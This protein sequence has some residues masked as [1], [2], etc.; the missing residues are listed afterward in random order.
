M[1]KKNTK[2]INN[3]KEKKLIIE[4]HSHNPFVKFWNWGWGIYYSNTLSHS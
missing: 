1:T 4:G 2:S 3:K